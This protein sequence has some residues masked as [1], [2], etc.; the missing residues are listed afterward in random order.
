L[1]RPEWIQATIL[2]LGFLVFYAIFR[3]PD[4]TVIDG[5]MRSCE[6]YHRQ[7]I[8]FHGNNHLLYP[9]NVLMWDRLMN[10]VLGACQDP[11]QFARRTQLMNGFA[12]A[13]SVAILFLLV[14]GATAS[15]GIAIWSACAYGFSRALLLHATN[16]AEPPVGLLLSFL[17]VVAAARAQRVGQGWLAAL[18]GVLLAAAMATYQSMILVGPAVLLLCVAPTTGSVAAGVSE[19][20]GQLQRAIGFLL[21]STAGVAGIY[22]WA[23]TCLRIS[24]FGALLNRFFTVDGGTE[25]HGGLSLWKS[26]KTPIGLVAH[27][28]YALPLDFEGVGW[29]LHNHATDGWVVW[30]LVLLLATAVVL[31]VL[32]GLIQ[33]HW[34]NLSPAQRIPL[35]AAV[36]ALTFT[37]VG[38]NYWDPVYNKMWLQPI[39][40][41]VLLVGMALSALPPSRGR[42]ALMVG[43]MILV[44]VEVL[45][46]CLWVIPN[47]SHEPPYLDEARKVEE[48]VRPDDLLI[49]EWDKVSSMHGG[50]YG[51]G[52]PQLCLP[53][54]AYDRGAAV[55][56]DIREMIRQAEARGGRVY[57]LGVMD[58]PEVTW[59]QF[60]GTRL[61]VPYHALDEFRDRC[62]PVAS[63]LIKG[64]NVTLQLYQSNQMSA[65]IHR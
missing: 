21:G 8:F 23:Y 26:I 12:A 45:S 9:V 50:V 15:S 56:D 40:A 39:A 61:H 60:L 35:A 62:R 18:A 32:A 30:L 59:N 63:F 54:A 44:L 47:M 14:R 19:S 7:E 33:R 52:R 11:L 25:V 38:P 28:F 34:G 48:I 20:R 2:F 24:G 1:K 46:S 41:L 27:L 57:F 36:V 49:Y 17:A 31:T 13:A 3:S 4:L 37:L 43:F 64:E 16:A 58:L 6:V 51:Y 53:Q 65:S 10:S 55:I 42:R 5:P 22:G 29:L